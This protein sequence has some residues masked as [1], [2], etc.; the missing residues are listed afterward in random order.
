VVSPD[1]D[2]SV[3]LLLSVGLPFGAALATALLGGFLGNGSGWVVL[4]AALGSTGLLA[5]L[6][7]AIGGPAR[8]DAA[9]LPAI[10]VRFTLLGDPF[11][12]FLA[13]LVT[14]VGVL[15]C[16]YSIGYLAEESEARRRRFYPALAA[17]MGSMVGIALADDLMLLFVFWELTSLTSFLLI[18]FRSEDEDAKAGALTALQVTAAG[19]L[20]MSVGFLLIGQVAGTFSLSAIVSDPDRL[21]R[22]L[23]SPLRDGALLLVL[24]GAFTKSAQVPFSFWLPAAMVAPTPVS[25]YLHAATMVKAGVFLVGRM[26]PIFGA[27]PLWCP[28]LVTVG[29]A[30][31]L[32][33]A[34]QAF[35]ENDLKAVLAHTTVA[36]LGGM[37]LLYGYG[38]GAAAQDALQM[39]SHALYKG[40]LFLV[41]GIVEH[42]ARTRNIEELGGL[43]RRLPLA[44]VACALAALSMAGIPPLLG[45]VAKE[46][47]LAELLHGPALAGHPVLHAVALGAA[48][49]AAAFIAA[50]AWRLVTVFLGTPTRAIAR[51][52]ADSHHEPRPPLWI[53]PLLLALGALGLG[54]LTATDLTADLMQAAS[55]RSDAHL[56]LG[57]APSLE[58]PFVVTVAVLALAVLLG[59][60]RQRVTAILG[61]LDVLPSG[62]TVWNGLIS[63][64]VRTGE[65]F[66]RRWQSGSLRW[67]LAATLASVPVAVGF[68]LRAGSLSY[69]DAGADLAD[70]P[71]YGLA[72]CVLLGVATVTAVRANTRLGAA[73]SMTSIGFLVSMLFVVYRS[74]DILLTQILIETVST[75]FIVLV[76]AFLP[77]FRP[78]DLARTARTV[79]LAVAGAFGLAIMVLVLLAMTPGL[80]ELD[81]VATRP[82][83]L[84]SLS[85]AEGGGANA[86]NV[87]IVDI[88]AMDTT[89]E[90]TVLVVVGLCIYGLLRT[91][92]SVS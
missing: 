91:R 38:L 74:P 26:L 5:R 92:R 6:A 44:F 39:L 62:Q 84:L 82:G 76:L 78:R 4:L 56:H 88:R 68:A 34:L 77:P 16:L 37:V 85:L 67:Y 79:N 48:L 52:L 19:G 8:V 64:I 7:L 17:F 73:I 36:A 59:R 13:L 15:V 80:R 72:L 43:R 60:D 31:M 87:I 75:I 58:A 22:L 63:A 90:I 81:N 50:V 1:P 18:G 29:A 27:S 21:A 9:W 10:D 3:L 70:A 46:A 41:A 25:T 86:V 49:V 28:V 69:R 53:S 32:L 20:V 33:G 23:D 57:L 11:G 65:G 12:L 47:L 14:G 83:G 40:A 24:C 35:R 66:S 2:P 42:T 51:R 61:R 71:W 54:V 89:G 55:S 45:F 30:T